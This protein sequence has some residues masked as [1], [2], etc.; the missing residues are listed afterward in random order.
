M[1]LLLCADRC[2][3]QYAVTR[4]TTHPCSELGHTEFHFD[5]Q[6]SAG[7]SGTVGLVIE[8]RMIFGALV[9]LVEVARGSVEAELALD[10][11]AAEP[12]EAH[13]H[14]LCLFGDNGLVGDSNG[15]GLVG[16]E[17]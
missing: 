7:V 5:H 12:V 15:G 11:A 17:G 14:G 16:L 3:I 1:Q 2:L 9:S 10:I 4:V 13:V 8:G 6:V